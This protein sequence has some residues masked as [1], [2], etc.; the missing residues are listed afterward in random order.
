MTDRIDDRA[1]AARLAALAAEG[2]D[3]ARALISRRNLLGVGA[4]LF[5]WG[6]L[7]KYASAATG[8]PRL[9]VVVLRGGMDGL[10]VVVPYGD[11]SYASARGKLALTK[12][13]TLDID[14]FFGLNPSLKT[15]SAAFAAGEGAAVQAVC[16]PLRNR[17]HFDCQDNLENGMPGATVT[18]ATGWLNRLLA[19]LPTSAPIRIRGALEIGDAPLILRGPAPVLGWSPTWFQAADDATVATVY[20]NYRRVDPALAAVFNAGIRT[21]R[22]ARKAGGTYDGLSDLR[23]SFRGAAN[24]MKAAAG[25]RISVLSVGGWDTHADEGTA[26]GQ[27]ADRLA[28]LDQGLADFQTAL[29]AGI[30]AETVVVMVTEFGRTIAVNG[31]DGA[32]HGV[33]TVAL[34]AGGAIAG[35]KVHGKWP[36]LAKADQFEDGNLAPTTDLRAV[37]KGILQDHLG[38]PKTLL[39]TTIFPS[40]AAIKPMAG[41]IAAPAPK[42]AV[43]TATGVAPLRTDSPIGRWRAGLPASG[44]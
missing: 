27:L 34:L 29:G 43:A 25:P 39:D 8:D 5:S 36:G 16:T 3:E 35:G 40:S 42:A 17:S 31:T 14:G 6:M 2:C 7:P 44:G 23:K 26:T 21:D 24:L 37:F 4:G 13:S 28:D 20:A 12:A 33:G 41:L 1:A 30:W 19:A 11:P 18:A 32:D 9:L 15:L 22:L 38:V 10:S